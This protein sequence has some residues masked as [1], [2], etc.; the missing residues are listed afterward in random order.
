MREPF[1]EFAGLQQ[2]I[3]CLVLS[4]AAIV[5]GALW[6]IIIVLTKAIKGVLG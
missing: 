1:E 6:W 5:G 3:G 2:G 4:L